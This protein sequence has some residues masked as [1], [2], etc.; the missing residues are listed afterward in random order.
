MFT[1]YGLYEAGNPDDIKY[2]GVTSHALADRFCGHLTSAWRRG[3]PAAN[4]LTQAKQ[5]GISIECRAIQRVRDADRAAI[6]EKKWIAHYS[7]KGSL[8]NV[9]NNPAVETFKCSPSPQPAN[10]N[11]GEDSVKDF[12]AYLRS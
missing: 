9:I 5:S 1:I 2:I 12:L 10:T 3:H 11:F 4:W 7:R 8:L 6:L